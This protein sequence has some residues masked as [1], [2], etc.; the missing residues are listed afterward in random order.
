MSLRIAFI[1][2]RHGHIMAVHALAKERM[3]LEIVGACEEDAATREA[4]AGQGVEATHADYAAL[5]SETK[6]DIVA[7]GDYYGIRGQRAVAALEA[8]CHVIGDK[9]LC[10]GLDEL[11]RIELL[12]RNKGLCVGCQL[13]LARAGGF[14]TV[15]RLVREGIL[16]EV[17][18]INFMGQ[19]PLLFGT[20]PGWYFEQGK[21]GGS[22]ND[23]AIHA[24][25]LIPWM[26]GRQIVAITAARVWN[27]NLPQHP[28][29][30]D[31]AAMM[32]RLDN[33]GAALGDVSYLAPTKPGYTMPQYW[34]FTVVGSEAT[35]EVGC[36]IDKVFL[37]KNDNEA[38][39]ILEPEAVSPS[40]YLDDFLAEIAGN[41]SGEGLNTERVVASTRVAL[42]TQ[43]AADN[44][45][46]PMACAPPGE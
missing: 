9:P 23:I 34:R 36:N 10:T 33:G 39:E 17:H 21:H 35:A 15:R 22:I 25:D 45:D 44:R 7:I 40:F 27:A 16:G 37:W 41:P 8:G 11:E 6:P 29:F 4:L 38:V 12:A 28:H 32:L 5:L 42:L 18:T 26:T 13:D 30:Q 19:H 20:R 3:D 46:F 1:G 43:L 2:F 14:A 24:I 31:G